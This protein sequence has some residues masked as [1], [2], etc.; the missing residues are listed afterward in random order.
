MDDGA[1]GGKTKLYLVGGAVVAL[2][3][4]VAIVV[5]LY[6]LGGA[7]QSPLE[8]LRDIAVIFV[9]LLNLIVVV[10]LAGVVAALAYLVFQTRDRVIPLL[11]ELTGTM[12]RARGTVDF[13]SEEAVRPI[14][15]A[16][17]TIARVRAMV[18]E[19]AGK[20]GRRR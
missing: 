14:V 20:N 2:L 19:A 15:S 5:G 16:A 13:V 9:V 3:V 4:L 11:E 12:R 8:R 18:R 6:L 7:D 10:L 17:G 1:G